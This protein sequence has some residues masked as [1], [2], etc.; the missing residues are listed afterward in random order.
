M[1][2]RQRARRAF[3][4]ILMWKLSHMRLFWA[5]SG[6]DQAN[7][8]DQLSPLVIGRLFGARI[9]RAGLDSAD[10][11]S[12]GSLLDALERSDNQMTPHVWRTG[13]IEDGSTDAVSTVRANGPDTHIIDVL[14]SARDVLRQIAQSEI[15][16]SS[17]LHG[18]ICADALCI[19]NYWTPMSDR[20]IGGSHKFDG[21]YSAFGECI[22]R[23]DLVD[24][25]DN[26]TD[27]KRGWRPLPGFAARQ[28]DLLR[29]YPGARLG[30]AD[31]P[32]S[33]E[34]VNSEEVQQP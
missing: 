1:N 29:S 19:P 12:T 4:S 27:L 17:S 9:K 30:H 33:P 5:A 6:D 16:F 23:Y 18:L 32:G 34:A 31:L 20:V 7:F 10:I 24:S 25:T 21:Y 3:P 14:A 15:I 8:G 26:T 28:R 13:F 22:V 11:V 2:L